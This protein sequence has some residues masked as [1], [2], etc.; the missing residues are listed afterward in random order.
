MT[1]IP[2]T[3]ASRRY[4]EL[5]DQMDYETF[6][7][8]LRRELGEIRSSIS[9]N[10]AYLQILEENEARVAKMLEEALEQLEA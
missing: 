2:E 1:D 3:S 6:V 7:E 10:R 8:A 5:K 9:S 4:A